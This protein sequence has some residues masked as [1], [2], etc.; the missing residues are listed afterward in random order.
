MKKGFGNTN[1]GHLFSHYPY[2]GYPE[3]DERNKNS[4]DKLIHKAK[5]PTSF[6]GGAYPSATF[7]PDYALVNH[8]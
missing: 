2:Q 6:V 5:I 8:S 7:T 4:Q 1:V 3:Q